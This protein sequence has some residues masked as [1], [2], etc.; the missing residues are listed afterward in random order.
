VRTMDL[1]TILLGSILIGGLVAIGTG[2]VA[3]AGVLHMLGDGGLQRQPPVT[4]ASITARKREIHASIRARY[5]ARRLQP[6]TAVDPADVPEAREL[7]EE[8]AWPAE[9]SLPDAPA[10]SV[11]NPGL[12]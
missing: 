12:A 9:P 7:H 3:V 5:L 4:S 2:V 10:P 11:T 6:W 1:A 8:P